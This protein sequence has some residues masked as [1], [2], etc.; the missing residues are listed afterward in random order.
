MKID[1]WTLALQTINVIVLLWVL[2]RFLFKPVLAVIAQRQQ[3]TQQTMHDATAAK[4]RADQER[5]AL[6]A[7]RLQLTNGREQTLA[8]AQ[9][10]AQKARDAMMAQANED[11]RQR[12]DAA[13]AALQRERN[14]ASAAL[15]VKAS[16]LAADIARRLLERVP[17]QSWNRWFIEG[18]CDQLARLAPA[19]LALLREDKQE[20][21]V[22]VISADAL[23]DGDQA[24]VRSSLKAMLA[25]EVPITFATDATLIAGVELRFRHM[26]ISNHWA[27][28]LKQILNQVMHQ[29]HRNGEPA[30]TI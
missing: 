3:A 18:T 5:A 30:R 2:Q 21:A 1:W 6:E 7:E 26:I 10:E 29:E 4:Q 17:G 12:M 25:R 19:E 22:K 15:Q 11:I 24:F 9:A 27:A 14:E 16:A 28:D 20:A 13:R 23:D 8:A